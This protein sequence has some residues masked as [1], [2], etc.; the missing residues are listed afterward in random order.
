MLESA[1]TYNG[2]FQGLVRPRACPHPS[3]DPPPPPPQPPPSKPLLP[4]CGPCSLPCLGARGTESSWKV[5][6]SL[7]KSSQ[8][9][10]VLPQISPPRL[11]HSPRSVSECCRVHL[12]ARQRNTEGVVENSPF[13]IS[14]VVLS[15]RA[16]QASDRAIKMHQ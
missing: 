5:K 6:C 15:E 8:T 11:L 9:P 3:S 16:F 1:E 7:K 2:N 12:Y 14:I 10:L 13:D 4:P